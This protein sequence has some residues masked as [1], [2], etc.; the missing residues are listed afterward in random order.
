MVPEVFLVFFNVFGRDGLVAHAVEDGERRGSEPVLKGWS[1]EDVDS[2]D[3]V[4]MA[5]A[6]DF[7]GD[8]DLERKMLS[9]VAARAIDRA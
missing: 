3:F 9:V 6:G 2:T 5:V 1:E 7:G 8:L 4:L